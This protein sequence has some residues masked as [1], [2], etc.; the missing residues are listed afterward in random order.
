MASNDVSILFVED[1]GTIRVLIS[2]F[3]NS[4]QFKNVYIAKDGREGLAKYKKYKPDIIL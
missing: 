4:K 3:L 1:N 2:E